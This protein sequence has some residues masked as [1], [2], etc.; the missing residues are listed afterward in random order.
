MACEESVSALQTC[1]VILQRG[2]LEKVR[3]V[4]L[5]TCAGSSSCMGLSLE[6]TGP[7]VI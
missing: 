2:G 5:M 4:M 1:F 7:Q 3:V 6:V